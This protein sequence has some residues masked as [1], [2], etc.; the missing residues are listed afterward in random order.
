MA[1]AQEPLPAAWR[2]AV[3][4]I[5]RHEGDCTWKKVRR[6]L[7]AKLGLAK[8]DAKK[9]RD[10]IVAL[11]AENAAEAPAPAPE[12]RRE[13]VAPVADMPRPA[14]RRTPAY[15][16]QQ[17]D[18]KKQ[19][20]EEDRAARTAQTALVGEQ[21]A[22]ISKLEHQLK[23]GPPYVVDGCIDIQA[24]PD[25][26]MI[27]HKV[28][29]DKFASMG[30]TPD[31]LERQVLAT[32]TSAKPAFPKDGQRH[33]MFYSQLDASGDAFDLAKDA[34][35]KLI[36]PD[37]EHK[38]ALDAVIALKRCN[39][40][41]AMGVFMEGCVT[42]WHAHTFLA[43]LNK[44]LAGIKWWWFVPPWDVAKKKD[45]SVDRRDCILI[46]QEP[47]DVLYF[48]AGWHHRVVT[49]GGL[50]VSSAKHFPTTGKGSF[51]VNM[52]MW[53]LPRARAAMGMLASQAPSV[54]E[55]QARWGKTLEPR[56]GEF[57]E[58]MRATIARYDRTGT[59]DKSE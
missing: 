44:S 58:Q 4:E 54:S 6:A 7:E 43:V 11:A 26:P 24:M 22:R 9:C 59:M 37:A 25:R 15:L 53:V 39:S 36:K 35:K 16:A 17:R 38:K 27:V 20:R 30:L 21:Q 49:H 13:P 32:I 2:V 46:K 56:S 1:A 3:E 19:K 28:R 5:L 14:R 18:A 55:K 8:G 52:A 10:A 48:P 41:A 23:H 42:D 33:G 57:I 47:G 45:V 50:S 51:S 40:E 12:E 34:L 29:P 31:V